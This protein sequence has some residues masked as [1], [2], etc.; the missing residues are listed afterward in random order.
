MICQALSQKS[1][2]ILNVDA[3]FSYTSDTYLRVCVNVTSSW[4]WIY[5]GEENIVYLRTTTADNKY[6]EKDNKVWYTTVKESSINREELN[7]LHIWDEV[8]EENLFLKAE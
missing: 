2:E 5:T 6:I 1:G 3:E 4:H 7:L 8:M